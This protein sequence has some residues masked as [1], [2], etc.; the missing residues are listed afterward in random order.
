MS[1]VQV[2]EYEE[3]TDRDD[4]VRC[5]VELQDFERNLDPRL[6][7][8]HS[9]ADAYTR[10]L[11]TKCRQLSGEIFVVEVDGSIAGYV[12]VWAK[13]SS[14]DVAE[15]P[16]EYALVK[17][18]VVLPEFRGRGIGRQLLGVAQE[19]ARNRH[20]RYLRVSVLSENALAKELYRSFG[21]RDREV[22]LDKSLT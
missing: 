12:C 9:I 14:D 8:G 13:V 10:D 19:F 20:A 15:A 7:E 17:D 16:R 2:R 4:L 5:V 18:L 22:T 6:P 11:V 1:T 3:R 21:F